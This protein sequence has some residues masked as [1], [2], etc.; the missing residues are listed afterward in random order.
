MSPYL[1]KSFI[2]LGLAAVGTLVGVPGLGVIAANFGT[3]LN[4]L[5]QELGA[6]VIGE[7]VEK[8]FG[9]T[10]VKQFRGTFQVRTR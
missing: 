6:E 4:E 3:F 2:A 5:A 9:K 7:L 1:V 8:H 10:E